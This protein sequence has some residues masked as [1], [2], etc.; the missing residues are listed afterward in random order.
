LPKRFI[1]PPP[2]PASPPLALGS[3]VVHYIMS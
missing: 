3:S 2:Q 1:M